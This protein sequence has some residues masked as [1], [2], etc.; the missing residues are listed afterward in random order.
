MELKCFSKS[1]VNP[2]IKAIVFVISLGINFSF[3]QNN[4]HRENLLDYIQN[5][6]DT[7]VLLVQKDGKIIFEYFSKDWDARKPH[8]LWSVTKSLTNMLVGIAVREKKLSLEESLCDKLTDYKGTPYCQIKVID[9]LNH[10]SGIKWNEV[11]EKSIVESSPI[12]MLYGKGA[13]ST[14]DFVLSFPHVL[15][16]T[17]GN[18]W[19]YSSGDSNLLT[20][21]LQKAYSNNDYDELPWK[22][23]AEPLGI[24]SLTFEQDKSGS[25]VGASFGYLNAEDALKWGS[26]LL[27]GDGSWRGREILPKD[28][29]RFSTQ[30]PEPFLKGRVVKAP[31]ELPG[32][33]FWPNRKVVALGARKP[34]KDLP[35]D[36]FAALGHWGQMLGVLPSENLVVVRFGIDK[37][38]ARKYQVNKLMHLVRELDQ[39]RKILESSEISGNP[40]L[41]SSYKSGL[42]YNSW[43]PKIF[44]E[45][46]LFSNYRAKDFCS[47]FYV[48]GQSEEY[49]ENFVKNKSVPSFLAPVRIHKDLKEISVNKAKA[50]YV[51]KRFGC[52]LD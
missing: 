32:R 20:K 42:R 13:L 52:V 11:Y 47:C 19:M 23:F 41:V 10:S 39:N 22:K 21:I 3:S 27:K 26:F 46:E 48:F 30:V 33:H 35:E 44:K 51:S 36:F 8:E 31:L 4:L 37:D 9:I 45:V 2:M 18:R 50:H 43:W 25:F 24:E 17:P 12:S 34:W 1:N 7:D 14:A 5:Q 16:A 49:C 29:I 38:D 6:T 40:E 15:E 28:W